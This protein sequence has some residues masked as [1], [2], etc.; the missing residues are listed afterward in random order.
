MELILSVKELAETTVTV[1]P[2]PPPRGW[3]GARA[4]V[5]YSQYAPA[6]HIKISTIFRY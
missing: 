1:P 5:P 6:L 3:G 4:P 2:M